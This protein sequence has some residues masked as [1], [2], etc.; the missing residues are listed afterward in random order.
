MATQGWDGIERRRGDR[1]SGSDR[2]LT[3]RGGRDR[4]LGQRRLAAA[5]AGLAVAVSLAAPAR[6]EAQIYSWRDANGTLVLSDRPLDPSAKTFAV[7]S[8]TQVRTTTPAP[9][10]QQAA[11]YDRLIDDHAASRGIRPDLVRAV[12]QVESNFNPRARSSKGA[13]GLMQLMPA[14]AS[15][16]GVVDPFNPVENIRGGV[17]YLR[18]LLDLYQNDEELALAAYNA[19]PE[20]VARHGTKVPPF[21]ETQQYVKRVLGKSPARAPARVIY[22]T[23]EIIDGRAVPH[24]SEKKPANGPYEIVQ[25]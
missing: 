15:E 14:T 4:R 16:L 11:A 12:I 10:P 3:P 21:R 18:Q 13:L 17:A 23:T 24:Y 8:A 9:L 5:A 25:K 2:R 22:K 6:A 7:P 20:A 1:R 19:G